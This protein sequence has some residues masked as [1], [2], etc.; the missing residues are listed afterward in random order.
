MILHKLITAALLLNIA[1]PVLAFDLEALQARLAEPA[2]IQGQFEQRSWLADQE[3]RLYSEGHFLYQRD[4]Q[5]IWQLQTPVDTTLVFHVDIVPTPA[6][7]VED[8]EQRTDFMLL[9][10]R[11]AFAQQLVDLIGGNWPALSNYY[12]ITLEGEPEQWQVQLTPLAPPMETWLGT[13][14]LEGKEYLEQ[15]TLRAANGDELVVRLEDQYPV[16][17]IALQP[18]FTKQFDH[19]IDS[20]GNGDSEAGKDSGDEDPGEE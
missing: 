18:F 19:I 10:E 2:T 4:R 15:I 14:T 8:E 9:T 6:E 17:E 11:F 16:D 20:E 7:N 13:L 3:T 1:T 5:V 12:H